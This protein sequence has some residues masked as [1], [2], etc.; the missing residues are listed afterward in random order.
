MDMRN[1]SVFGTGDL[2][3]ALASRCSAEGLKVT[4][5]VDY[6]DKSLPV[7]IGGIE[8]KKASVFFQE[9]TTSAILIAKEAMFASK[10]IHVCKEHLPQ[11]AY[12]LDDV[13]FRFE[14]DLSLS[15]SLRK[16]DWE[17]KASLPYIETNI[18]DHCNLNCR[19]C[20]HFSNVSKPWEV[21]FEDLSIQLHALAQR[22]DV[23]QLRLLGGEPLLHS[24][25]QFVLKEVRA[26]LP[27]SAV[28]LAT[29]GLLIA[30]KKRF[31]RIADC[32]KEYGIYIL[33]TEYP[34]TTQVL[35]TAR[36]ALS[37]Y[38]I[39]YFENKHTNKMGETFEGRLLSHGITKSPET[40]DCSGQFCRFLRGG[41]ISKCPLPLLCHIL[42]D[43]WS[44]TYETSE[45]DYFE[46][47]SIQDG[48]D[49]LAQ[50][51][52]PVPFCRY[53]SHMPRTFAWTNKGL[54]SLSDYQV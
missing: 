25:L 39:K 40:V 20:S 17:G 15:N 23:G 41:L 19:G 52:K 47:E 46:I 44:T 26:A 31:S 11:H 2:G 43:K 18:V 36:E 32:F 3:L 16:V 10:A 13:A 6:D 50:L 35:K 7:S 27:R 30:N 33:L 53:C 12:L 54:P 38:G 48:W 45:K 49:A 22:F 4:C 5:F 1:V 21:S 34:A 14:P 37:Y 29:N 9:K 24:E 8:V 28:V 42:N 51:Q